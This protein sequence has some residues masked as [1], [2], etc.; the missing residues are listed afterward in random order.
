MEAGYWSPCA[1]SVWNQGFHTPLGRLS[2]ST[3]LVKAPDIRFSSS[4]FRKQHPRHKKAMSKTS[5]AEAI[6]T[7]T[8]VYGSNEHTSGYAWCPNTHVEDGLREWIQA[9]FSHLVIISVIFTAGRG[10]G[11]KISNIFDLSSMKEFY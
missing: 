1:P 7:L 4:Q 10:D 9:E 2:V 8:E 3:N 5:L 6:N 11:N